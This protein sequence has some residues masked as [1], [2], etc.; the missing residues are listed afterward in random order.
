[1]K[2]YLKILVCFLLLQTAGSQ[3]WAQDKITQKSQ[4]EM[5]MERLDKALQLDNFQKATIQAFLQQNQEETLKIIA[6][7]KLDDEKIELIKE[8]QKKLSDQIKSVLN[9]EQIEIFENIDK[10]DSKNKK[11]KKKH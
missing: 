5:V 11:K 1:M 9:P 6:L 3:T 7:N 10:K 2:P 8:V 4:M